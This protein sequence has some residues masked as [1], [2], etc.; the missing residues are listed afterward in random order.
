M[1]GAK[2]ESEPEA[3]TAIIKELD[4]ST[5]AD[6]VAAVGDGSVNRI[7]VSG[8]LTG[9]PQLRLS[10]DQTLVGSGPQASVRFK[11]GSDGI[12]LSANNKVQNL[13]L[14]ATSNKRVVFNDTTVTDFG[15]LELGN[16]TMTGV[17]QLLAVDRVRAGRVEVHGIDIVSAD[18]RA[19]DVRPKGYGVEVVPG[20][21]TLWNQQLD[22]TVTITADLTGLSAGRPDAP[23]RGSGI[24]ISGASDTGGRLI[25][26]RLE[27]DAIYSNGGI[28]QG[29][30]DRISGGVFTVH[31]AFVDIVR[32]RGPVTTYGPNDMVLDNW[33]VVD[34]WISDER[35]SSCGPS[36]IGFV[37]FGNINS[38][39]IN[40]PIETFGQGARGFNVYAGTVKSAEFDRIVTH[41]NGAVGI[42]I[43]R[44]VGEISVRR[45]V[46]TFGGS[47][48][49]LVKGVMT[50]LSA[51][52]FSIK[53]EGSVQRLKIAGGLITHG[54]G[55]APLD[56]Q[57]GVGSLQ[58]K[59]GI[60]VSGGKDFSSQ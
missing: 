14:V 57:G 12:Q 7:V 11:E 59:D 20:A 38:L 52:A 37:N 58:V 13:R 18:S 28:V 40:A 10:P 4:V 8:D 33:G 15:V 27:T 50:K 23:V 24:F 5:A 30:A 22:S 9:L 45:G 26:N 16:L 53:P 41:G 36:A 47:G 56:L 29:T 44:P 6:L 1:P 32:T 49:S 55:I 3:K 46:E 35:I 31:G 54:S 21:F 48:D 51:V 25:V 42:Q 43:G 19:Y 34:R 2:K 17:V 39:R 60:M